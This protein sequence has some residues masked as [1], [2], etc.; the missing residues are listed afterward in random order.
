MESRNGGVHGFYSS[1]HMDKTILL[2]SDDFLVQDL[3]HVKNYQL[4]VLACTKEKVPTLWFQRAG[5]FHVVLNSV[6]K[7]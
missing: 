4:L 1:S 2:L 5:P 7:V 6:N 3:Y